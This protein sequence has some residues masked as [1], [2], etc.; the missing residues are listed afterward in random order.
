MS[1]ESLKCIY[2]RISLKCVTNF[3]VDCSGGEPGED[4]TVSLEVAPGSFYK[5][6]FKIVHPYMSERCLVKCYAVLP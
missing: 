5:K 3:N 1:N 2:K 4:A 6:R